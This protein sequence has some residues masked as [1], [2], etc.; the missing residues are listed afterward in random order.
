M[1]NSYNNSSLNNCVTICEEDFWERVYVVRGL[2]FRGRS[3][4]YLLNLGYSKKE[5]QIAVALNQKYFSRK[6][7]NKLME[8]GGLVFIG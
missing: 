7:S 5:I 8:C 1:I 4:E 3:F 2:L 6:I